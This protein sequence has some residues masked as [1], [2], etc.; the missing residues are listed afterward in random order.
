MLYF[1]GP[2]NAECTPIKNKATSIGQGDDVTK[3]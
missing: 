2:R 1:T 3:P